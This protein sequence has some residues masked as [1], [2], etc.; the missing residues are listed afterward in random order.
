MSSDPVSSDPSFGESDAKR[1][2]ARAAT[3]DAQRSERLDAAALRAI[4]A[5]AGISPAAVDQAIHERLQAPAPRMRSWP[6]RH[7]G[8]LIILGLVGAAFLSRLF[9]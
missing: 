9:P 1:I 6:A 2:I 5:E 3:L 7:A 4:A 8:V